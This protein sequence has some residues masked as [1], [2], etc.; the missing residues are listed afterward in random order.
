MTYGTFKV[1]E[2]KGCDEASRRRKRWR[3][4]KEN[5]LPKQILLLKT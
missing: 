5:S 4:W 2:K 3:Y 1:F